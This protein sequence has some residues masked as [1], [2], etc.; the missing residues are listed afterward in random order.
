MV[1]RVY[2]LQSSEP[3]EEPMDSH[4]AP[5]LPETGLLVECRPERPRRPIDWGDY[6]SLQNE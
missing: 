2:Q 4:D 5:T 1:Y 3:S 6:C